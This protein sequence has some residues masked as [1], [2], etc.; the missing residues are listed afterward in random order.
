MLSSF[1]V[2]FEPWSYSW[3]NEWIDPVEYQELRKEKH[4]QFLYDLYSWTIRWKKCWYALY[5]PTLRLQ[6]EPICCGIMSTSSASF[7]RIAKQLSRSSSLPLS[8]MPR[9][10]GTR[11][12]LTSQETSKRS[13]LRWMRSLW[14]HA[15][16]LLRR[17]AWPQAPP[18]RRGELLGNTWKLPQE[19]LEFRPVVQHV[20]SPAEITIKKRT[21]SVTPNSS[22]ADACTFFRVERVWWLDWVPSV[23]HFYVLICTVA[24]GAVESNFLM[25]CCWHWFSFCCLGDPR[26]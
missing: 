24:A 21:S 8:A 16:G 3:M 6:R 22:R 23:W 18:W 10:T 11:Q 15:R 4:S 25:F 13:C 17:R 20:R 2:L 7:P 1:L 9:I 12:S 5:L 14:S 19:S 26:S